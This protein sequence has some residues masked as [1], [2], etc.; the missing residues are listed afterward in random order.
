MAG[1]SALVQWQSGHVGGQLWGIYGHP[2]RQTAA[3]GPQ[4]NLSVYA[5]DDRYS[6]DV[7]YLGG[8]KTASEMAQYAISQVAMNAL[9]TRPAYAG[10]GWQ[11]EWRQR[12]EQ[13]PPWTLQWL[14]HQHD[15]PYWR[16][17]LTRL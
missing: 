2:G 16:G 8:C 12:L 5:T 17:S 15:G 14:H 3:A 4:G 11:A 13:T 6:D 9:P 1:R 10:P 7:H